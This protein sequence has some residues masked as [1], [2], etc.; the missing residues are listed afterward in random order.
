MGGL[1]DRQRRA[2]LAKSEH[3]GGCGVERSFRDARKVN[4]GAA[5]LAPR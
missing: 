5:S 3:L 2:P 4:A 1:P